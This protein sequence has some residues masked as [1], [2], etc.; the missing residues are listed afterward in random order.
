MEILPASQEGF[1]ISGMF[2]VDFPPTVILRMVYAGDPELVAV[3]GYQLSVN[4]FYPI[5]IDQ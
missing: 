4:R 1:F 2:L 5:T 3:I